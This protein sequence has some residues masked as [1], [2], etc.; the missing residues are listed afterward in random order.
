MPDTY[1]G[2]YL[3]KKLMLLLPIICLLFQSCGKEPGAS[4]DEKDIYFV[5]YEAMYDFVPSA[6]QYPSS[7][8][9]TTI[10]Y[11]TPQ[12]SNTVTIQRGEK[13]EVTAGPFKKG[14]WVVINGGANLAS[15]TYS[16][17]ER[18]S[19]SI[20]KDSEPFVI[21]SSSSSLHCSCTI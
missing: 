3:M 4:E 9:T 7:L 8:R 13:F 1:Q 12:G 18:S 6:F 17:T 20:S 2:I 10:T 21:R 14:D 11:T 16:F 19:I 15:S 5:K